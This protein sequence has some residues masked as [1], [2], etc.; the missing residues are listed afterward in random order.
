VLSLSPGGLHTAD[1]DNDNDW[2]KSGSR[3]G[4]QS[5]FGSW[6]ECYRE[7]DMCVP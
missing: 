1:E 5:C 6:E 7:L 3:A 2:A 4:W